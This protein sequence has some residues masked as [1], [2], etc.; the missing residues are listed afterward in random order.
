MLRKYDPDVLATMESIRAVSGN[1]ER[2]NVGRHTIIDGVQVMAGAWIV[3]IRTIV[4]VSIRHE[5]DINLARRPSGV[6]GVIRIEARLSRVHFKVGVGDVEEA[7]QL[8]GQ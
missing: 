1:S 2:G 6:L 8:T 5:F 4:R 7:L 3:L